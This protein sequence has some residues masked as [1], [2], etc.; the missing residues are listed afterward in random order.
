MD[1]IS[2]RMIICPNLFTT[3]RKYHRN[4]V[5][6]IDWMGYMY[7]LTIEIYKP[8]FMADFIRVLLQHPSSKDFRSLASYL[9]SLLD[10]HIL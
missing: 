8:T 2:L 5:F 10:I 7:E 1:K 6:I 4:G 9:S 3:T